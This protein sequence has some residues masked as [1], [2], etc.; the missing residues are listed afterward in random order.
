MRGEGDLG[1]GLESLHQD[2]PVVTRGQHQAAC[3]GIGVLRDSQPDGRALAHR[4]DD[5]RQAEPPDQALDDL[6][7]DALLDLELL[8]V[9]DVQ[10][11]AGHHGVG[12]RLVHAQRRS[13]DARARIGNSQQLQHSLHCS[14]L[15]QPSVQRVEDDVGKFAVVDVR[16][17]VPFVLRSEYVPVRA[18]VFR[19]VAAQKSAGCSGGY[20][21]E[22]PPRTSPGASVGAPR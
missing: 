15:T 22:R 13:Q 7:G 19:G 6:G 3:G 20:E 8:E 4:L 1:A 14:V 17:G 16:P 18:A 5:Q 10:P 2:A 21:R 11:G 12:A 9:R